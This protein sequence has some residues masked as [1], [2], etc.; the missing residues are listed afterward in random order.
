M[1]VFS[2]SNL[3]QVGVSMILEDRFS[4][5]AREMADSF[6]RMYQD[7]R[8]AAQATKD[9]YDIPMRVLQSGISKGIE[10]YQKYAEV[11]KD[12]FLTAAMSGSPLESLD[13][14]LS[15]QEDLLNSAKKLNLEVPLTTGDIASAQKFMA[16]AGMSR[17]LILATQKPITQLAS[18]FTMD[19]GGKGGVADIMTNIMATFQMGAE[20]ARQLGDDILI[21]TTR[22]NMNLRDLGDAIK[23]SGAEMM[24]SGI[25]FREG[26]AAIG[27]LGDMGIQGSAAGTAIANTLRYLRLSISGQ[28]T[29]GSDALKALGLSREDFLDAKGNLHGLH[30]MYTTVAK[31]IK[32]KGLTNDEIGTAFY[33]IFGV[34]G[35]RNMLPII[36]QL[37]SGTDKM[38]MVLQEMAS[39]SGILDQTMT[40]YM[41]TDA[42]KLDLWKSNIDAFNVTLGQSTAKIF[43]PALTAINFIF[44]QINAFASSGFGSWLLRSG[45]VIMFMGSLML[46]RRMGQ[47]FNMILNEVREIGASMALSGGTMVNRASA[48]RKEI[49]MAEALM[50]DIALMAT[51]LPMG[52]AWNMGKVNGK[53][54]T[55]AQTSNGLVLSYTDAAGKGQIATGEQAIHGAILANRKPTPG[56]TTGPIPVAASGLGKKVGALGGKLVG[57]M[58]K[59][60]AKAA[61][62][63]IPGMNIAMGLWML[64]DIGSMLFGAI[65]GNTKAQEERQKQ[66]EEK[67][68]REAERKAKEDAIKSMSWEDYVKTQN[69]LLIDLLNRVKSPDGKPIGQVNVIVNGNEVAKLAAEESAEVTYGMLAD[70]TGGL[71][72]NLISQGV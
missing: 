2:S 35:S 60:G 54:A 21:A 25:S 34:R 4:N 68:R 64:W 17:D 20:N 46:V 26:A 30:Q 72:S 66:E 12:S 65:K 29:K 59:L 3:I 41:E 51:T 53:P 24:T 33:N 27:L 61:G 52:A 13:Q 56:S 42:G 69:A 6:R 48:F 45:L 19:A 36:S 55:I 63:M 11:G 32:A 38:S 58:A 40:K 8:T 71:Q 62:L 28:K 7:I 15:H 1:A 43:G 10:A 9:A 70:Y 37:A 5:P 22:S 16:M 50:K 14:R 47:H 44:Q 49:Q 23:Y 18:I 39:Q 67:M 31:A 57:G